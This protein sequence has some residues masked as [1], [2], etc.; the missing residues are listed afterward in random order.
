MRRLWRLAITN[1]WSSPGRTAAAVISVA[2]GVGTVVVITNVY[3]TA[4]RTVTDDV[5]ARWLGAAHVSIYPPGAH[6]GTLD[7]TLADALRDIDNVAHVTARLQRRARLIP[8]ADAD[9]L[10]ESRWSWVDAIGITPETDR[11]FRTLPDLRGRTIEPNERGVAVIDRDIASTWNLSLGDAIVLAPHAG[12]TR[13]ALTVVGFFGG[14]KVAEFQQSAVYLALADVQGL[15][16]EPDAVSV[17]DVMLTDATQAPLADAKTAIEAVIAARNYPYPYRVETAAAR[18]MV[19]GEADRIT[20]L[21]LMLFAFISLLTSFFIILT[22]QSVSL[23]QRRP[24]LGTMRCLGLTRGQ[25]VTLMFAELTPL[26][27]A[28]TLLGTLGGLGLTWLIPCWSQAMVVRMH[29]SQWG[30]TLAIAS[31]LLT[32]LLSTLLLVYQVGRLSPM[33]AVTTQARPIRVRWIYLTGVF[34]AAL[35]ALHQWMAT[36]AD[37]ERWLNEIFAVVGAGSLYLGYVLLAPTA[38]MLLGRPMARL[39][40]RL[41]GLRPA[42]VEE[43]IVK[44]PWRSTGACWVLMV[45]VSL[46]VYVA[47]RGESIRAL[48]DFP[49]KLPAAFVWSSQYVSGE[50]IERVRKLPGVG[51]S[52]VTTDLACQIGT[53]DD[54]PGSMKESLVRALLE[55]VNRPVFVAGETDEIMDMIK[56]VFIEGTR[57]DAIVKLKRGGY[58]LLP[59]QTAR[60]RNRH[61]GDRVTVTIGRKT[62]E[63]EVA[64]VVQ[65][66]AL[67]LA[68]TAFQAES[69]MQIASASAVLGTRADLINKFGIDAVAMFMCDIDLPP[70][71]PPTGFDPQ[72]LPDHTSD[73]AVAQAALAW[74]DRLPNES[75]TMERIGPA[76]KEW[77]AQETTAPPPPAIRAELQ[78]FAKALQRVARTQSAGRSVAEQW[79]EFRER[80]VLA[81]IAQ[82]MDRPDAIVGSLRRLKEQVDSSLD[83]AIIV[84]TWLPSIV[85]AVAAI[86]IGNLM[87]VS[88]HQRSRQIAV[89]RAVGALK[90]QIIRLVLAEAI[91]LALLG[92]VMGVAL[93]LHEAASINRIAATLVDV[94][95]AFI[96]PL[97]TL[98]L[99]IA[100]TVAVCIVSAI[101][102]A[103]HAA[104]NNI[105]EAMQVT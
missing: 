104:R 92:S 81:R 76:L 36:G 42:L 12:G 33:E 21:I 73:R 28:G 46:I 86:G 2:I 70:S 7:P 103:R 19:L 3:E 83:Q 40:G 11:H 101:A 100:L 55:K 71:E 63:F 78:R 68:V 45:G 15:K 8:A 66:P 74:A 85:L 24:Q 5:V 29:I 56:I 93:G 35:L 20:R 98:S 6:W 31:G 67:D 17:I 32:T 30:L 16:N 62:A 65:S 88:V 80:L 44:A 95:L 53:P 10:L 72:D 97:G 87:M 94:H 59:T 27:I 50:T 43:P 57:Q 54:Q 49:A 22:T 48:W 89:L 60:N 64:G 13:T 102:P 18:Q 23:L 39:A 82:E 91:T 99:A 77:L 38:V 96:V 58:V 79:Q 69:Y 37:Q 51:E 4:R 84:V 90:S 52:T 41:M 34:G 1:W 14:Q 26:G 61:V 9:R 105:I 75:A 47:V 25:M